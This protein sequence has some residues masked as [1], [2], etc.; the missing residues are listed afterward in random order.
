M[1]ER[2]Q[3]FLYAGWSVEC[4]CCGAHFREFLPHGR[5]LRQ[6]A[7]CGRC[8]AVERHRVMM[9]YLQNRTD[10]FTA[11]QK[12][13]HF[14]PER[15]M[16]EIF[17]ATPTLQYVTTDYCEP[18]DVHMDIT[19]LAIPDNTFDAVICSHVLEHIP[20]DAKAMRELCRVLKPGGWAILQV[21]I[22]LKRDHTYED[23]T[24]TTPAER[25][26]H[27]GQ[28]DHVRWYGSDYPQ[29]LKTAGFDVTVDQF[30]PSLPAETI[31]KYGLLTSE[32]VYFCRKPA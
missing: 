8:D 16:R 30:V 31:A 23:F 12:L 9:L 24:I 10:L 4:P 11:K 22:D 2:A 17:S 3:P 27:F 1:Q 19:S 26:L 5:P 6:N 18:T 25:R 14:A 13:L 29:R 20:D 28:E 21:P 32:D 15:I 7:R